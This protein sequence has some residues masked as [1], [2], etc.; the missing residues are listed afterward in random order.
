MEN[1]KI[2]EDELAQRLLFSK[3]I[4]DKVDSG[5]FEKGSVD[6]TMIEETPT[7][8]ENLLSEIPKD[9]QKKPLDVNRIQNS[10]LPDAI[11]QAMIEHP[12][13]QISLNESMD[14][15]LTTKAKK[16]MEREGY[17]SKTPKAKSPTQQTSSIDLEN[18]LTPIIENIIRK[19]LDDIV[20]RKLNQILTASQTASINENLVIKVGDHI[21][22]GKIT[23][24]KN[25][26]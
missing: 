20:E 1:K 15:S 3:K 14:I 7:L 24:V 8:N 21:F 16:L 26:K 10:K 4:M 25:T 5:N 19:T 9:Q 6:R 22:K 2:T 23:G 12:I 17:S 13:Q 18:R 11:K